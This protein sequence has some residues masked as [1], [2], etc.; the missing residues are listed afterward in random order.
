MVKFETVNGSRSTN[1]GAKARLETRE[2]LEELAQQL[3]R[4]RPRA[5]TRSP[6][7]PGTYK[8]LYTSNPNAPG[9]PVLRSAPGQAVFT[10]QQ[11]RQTLEKPDMFLNEV[12]F[13]T[14][15]LF[16]GTALQEGRWRALDGNRYVV[17]LEPAALKVA[18]NAGLSQQSEAVQRK[19]EV[20]YLDE[21][22]RVV[23]FLPEADSESEPQLFV[24]EREVEDAEDDVEEEEDEPEE[25][26]AALP[27]LR[28]RGRAGLATEAER[29]Y[30]QEASAGTK[31]I[32]RKAAAEPAQVPDAKT[33][34]VKRREAVRA[35][36]AEITE[37]YKE[38]QAE[39]RTALK[40]LKDF[41]KESAQARRQSAPALDM[42]RV[43]DATAEAA[44][45]QLQAAR[46]VAA[47]ADEQLKAASSALVQLERQ[48]RQR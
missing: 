1:G 21:R 19:F 39:T 18:G 5:P 16:P 42:V 3:Q 37:A 33:E 34:E 29:S 25:E 48:V 26:A 17:D 7:F 14:L 44:E 38:A 13:K 47:N 23:R 27:F 24:F 9:G 4:F 15:G 40:Q 46:E 28:G 32:G 45:Q 35:Q 6:L 22:V 20:L 43:A 31:R 30:G 12:A 41:E 11:L 10:G 2:Q 8:V 36:L